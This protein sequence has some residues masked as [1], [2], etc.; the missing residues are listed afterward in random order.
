MDYTIN[1]VAQL[2]VDMTTK[3]ATNEELDRAVRYSRDVLDAKIKFFEDRESSYNLY[4]IGNLEMKYQG[5]T[6]Y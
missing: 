1:E 6:S 5:K 3:G 4:E 2:I